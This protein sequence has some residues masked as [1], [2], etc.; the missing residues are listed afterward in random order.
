MAKAKTAA[1]AIMLSLQSG[2]C[3]AG[4]WTVEVVDPTGVGK[5]S[6]MKLDT[7]GNVHIAYV[8]D[9]Q[10]H[11]PL[12]YAFW[13]HR[14][15][16]WFV[17]QAAQ[18][19]GAC[20]LALDAQQRPY[21]A[22]NDPGSGSGAKLRYAHWTGA[23]W[24]RQAIPLNSDVIAYYVS[25][26]FDAHQNPSIS[27][28]EYRGPKDS[29]LKIRLRNVL[30][31]GEYWE[32]RTVDPLEGSGKFNSMAAD[33]NGNLHLAY[34]NVSSNTAG[35]R[36]AFWDGKSWKAEVIEDGSRN[37]GHSVGY[38]VNIAVDPTGNPHIAYM[39]ETTPTLK[40]AVRKKGVWSIEAVDRLEAVGYPDRNGIAFGPDGE[41]YISYYD[42]GKGLLNVV[43]KTNG[44]WLKEVIDGSGAGFTS[45]IQ[46]GGGNV[47][48][49]YGDEGSG[50][51]KVAHRALEPASAASLVT[52]PQHPEKP[53]R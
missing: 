7:D 10:N 18:G 49:S 41:P 38:A 53:G 51:F 23:S 47:W 20:S 16:K 1:F 2:L 15:G 8:V 22:Y 30:W 48:V 9:D 46:I 28:Y 35:L 24:L 21:I 32:V 44:H 6:S 33:A 45:S 29:D 42:A 37:N 39:D 26:A 13:D 14:I 40:Y 3:A 17:M 19:A 36:Y 50:V 52:R 5:Y 4:G 11:F 31:N 27:F 25:T 12:K 34:A 43:H